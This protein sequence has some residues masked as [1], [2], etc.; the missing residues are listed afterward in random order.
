MSAPIGTA[1]QTYSSREQRAWYFYDWANSA[2]ASTVVTLFLGPYLTALAR[3]AADPQGLIFPLGIPIDARSYW[4]YLVSLSVF[5]QVLCLPVIGAVADSSSKKKQLLGLFA[6]IGA[7]ATMA[8]FFLEGSRYLLGGV[9][10]LTSNLAFGAAM[11]LY[12]AFLN[13]IAPESERDAVSSRG[14]GIGY[15][16]AGLLLSLNLLLYKNAA[17]LGF[18]EG[19][20][21]RVSLSS[22]GVWWALF[23][24][25]PMAGLRNRAAPGARALSNGF[26]QLLQTLGDMRRYPRTLHFLIAFLAYNE[27]IQAVI[28]LSGQYGSDY[29]KIPM[30][31]LTLAIL[32]VQFVAFAGA[33]LFNRLA[34]WITAKRAVLFSL[35]AWALLMVGM[36]AVKTTRGYF[37][38]AACVA[39]IMGGTQALSRSLFSLMI[40]AGR[41]AEYFSLYEVSD[42]G[43]SWLAPL[44]FGLTLQFTASYQFAILSLIVF[45]IVGLLLLAR[46]D[47]RRAAGEAGNTAP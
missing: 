26:R 10:F 30:A 15:L 34:Q 33:L 41:E 1:A 46:V 31:D 6:Y 29:L 22:A 16:G 12:N 7:F 37:I 4:S 8:M 36:Y 18:T 28:A 17:A 47:V 19:F 2:Y 11:V 35:V 38:A 43:T 44:L 45:F 13:D 42:K 9:L 27:G 3:R 21:V 23:T 24:L 39:L 40:P 14:W 25:I 20:A 5:T 32:M